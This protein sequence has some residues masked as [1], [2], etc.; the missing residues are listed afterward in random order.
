MKVFAKFSGGGDGRSTSPPN[1]QHHSSPTN[2]G[3]YGLQQHQNGGIFTGAGMRHDR[4]GK[5]GLEASG[6]PDTAVRNGHAAGSFDGSN[7][8]A[9]LLLRP[10][11]AYLWSFARRYI[12][13]D[14]PVQWPEY[15]STDVLS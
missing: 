2:G 4:S 9:E 1:Q 15:M 5:Y 6:L 11:E 13:P 7:L 10:A 14:N 8:W 3:G 12:W